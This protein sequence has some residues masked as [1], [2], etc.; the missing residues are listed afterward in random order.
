MNCR[1]EPNLEVVGDAMKLAKNI[2]VEVHLKNMRQWRWR[3]RLALPLI[4]LGAWI[5]GLGGVEIVEDE[6]DDTHQQTTD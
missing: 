6:E 4:I 5:G 3:L 2:I 1:C